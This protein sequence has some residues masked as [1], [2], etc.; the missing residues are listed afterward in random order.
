MHFSGKRVAIVFL[1]GAAAGPCPCQNT[2]VD[3]RTDWL[4]AVEFCIMGYSR[5]QPIGFHLSPAPKYHG[6]HVFCFLHWYSVRQSR[7]IFHTG[8]QILQP[9]TK[10]EAGSHLCWPNIWDGS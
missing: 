10:M 3:S 4:K 8:P 2:L 1:V 7:E 9:G 6:R 5:K